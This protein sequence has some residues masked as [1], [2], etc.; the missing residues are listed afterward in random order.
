[1]DNFQNRPPRQM[2]DISDLNITCAECGTPIKELPF[3][4]TKKEDGTYGKLYC[5]D[6]NRQR[7]GSFRPRGNFSR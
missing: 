7:K 4:P 2:F 1:M 6:C 5:R 3:Q